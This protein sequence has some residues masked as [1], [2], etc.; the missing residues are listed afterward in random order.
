M[1]LL[2]I[3]DTIDNYHYL[4]ATISGLYFTQLVREESDKTAHVCGWHYGVETFKQGLSVHSPL[5]GDDSIMKI[6]GQLRHIK[7]RDGEIYQ[8]YTGGFLI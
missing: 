3:Y 8:L 2:H 7:E 1:S 6:E 4:I 5:N